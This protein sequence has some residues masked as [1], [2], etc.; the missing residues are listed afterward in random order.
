MPRCRALRRRLSRY[1][2]LAHPTP[3]VSRYFRSRRSRV[4]DRDACFRSDRVI[5]NRYTYGRPAK[6]RVSGIARLRSD[7]HSRMSA[8]L[9]RCIRVADSRA[10][11][12]YA[13]VAT[14]RVVSAV[15]LA[16]PERCRDKLRMGARAACVRAV[17]SQHEA[18]RDPVCHRVPRRRRNDV[19]HR[20]RRARCVTNRD[21]VA[22]PI[23]VI[24]EAVCCNG[25]YWAYRLEMPMLFGV[26]IFPLLQLSVLT[27]SALGIAALLS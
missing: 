11:T 18:T 25:R 13:R 2:R 26:G 8:S 14:D 5:R 24:V 17:R 21:M 27:P 20:L 10:L 16:R 6:N 23:A 1:R 4:N 19:R 7:P 12:E 22:A 9:R 15:F 3:R